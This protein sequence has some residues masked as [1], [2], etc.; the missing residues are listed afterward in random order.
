M[1]DRTVKHCVRATDL[2]DGQYSA[3]SLRAGFATAAA[4][5]GIGDHRIAQ[6][7]RWRSLRTVERYVRHV[8]ALGAENPTHGLL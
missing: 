6:H 2:E 4:D 3:H 7:G 1:V 8:R 5:A